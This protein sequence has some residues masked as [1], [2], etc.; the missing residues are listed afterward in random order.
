VEESNKKAEAFGWGSFGEDLFGW[1]LGACFWGIGQQQKHENEKIFQAS[2]EQFLCVPH[3]P[4]SPQ[5]F[6]LAKIK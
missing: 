1:V 6:H 2:P 3:T 4:N 5:V